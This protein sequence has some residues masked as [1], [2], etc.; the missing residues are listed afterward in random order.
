MQA[1]VTMVFAT[2]YSL[3]M[4]VSFLWIIDSLNKENKFFAQE[5]EKQRQ[6]F[7]SMFD[8]LQEGIVVLQEGKVTFVN[9]LCAKVLAAVSGMQNFGNNI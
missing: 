3:V 1:I 7:Q 2:I 9:D 5:S 8:S 4:V 6:Q